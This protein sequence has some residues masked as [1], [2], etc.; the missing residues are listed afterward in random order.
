MNRRKVIDRRGF[1]KAAAGT[2]LSAPLFIPAAAIGRDG[3]TSPS[4]RITMGFIG[5]GSQGM[6]IMGGFLGRGDVR[7]VAVCDVD[8]NRLNN[9][10]DRVNNRYRN[11]DCA[12]YTDF[13]ELLARKDLDAVGLALP[14][15]WHAVPA[16]AAAQAGLDCYGEKPLSRSIRE[17]RAICDAVKRYGRVWQTGSQQRSS[18]NF[19]FA[20]ELVRNGVVGKIHTVEVGL[21]NGPS[22]G[23]REPLPVPDHIDWDMWL[24][25]APWRPYTNFGRGGPHWDWRWIMDYSGGQL[26]DW[27]GHH[28]DIAHWGLDLDHTGPVE[29]EGEGNFPR[30][31]IF[32][33]PTEYRFN[34]LYESGV[35]ILVANEGQLPHGRGTRFIGD[36]GWIHVHRGGLNASNSSWLQRDILDANAIRLYRS[37]NHIGNFID[38]VKTRRDP[39]V[40][41]ETGTRSISVAH[42]G[43]IAMITGRKIRWNPVTEE[44]IN[45]PRASALLGRS[46]REPWIL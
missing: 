21:P 10:R 8:R 6:G 29:V 19:R 12:V 25:P 26:T 15:H 43:E 37:N 3:N 46:Y 9:A 4:N 41:A 32:D 7:V 39:I 34:C 28:I 1:L 11:E 40:P 35:N 2:A 14:D 33:A 17:S 22:T 36:N 27:A 31:G 24:G 30:Q 16:I 20:C 44:I 23:T 18:E 42:L 5:T 45:D 13:R 38:C